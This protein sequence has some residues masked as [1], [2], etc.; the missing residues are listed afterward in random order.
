MELTGADRTTPFL[1]EANRVLVA[2][3]LSLSTSCLVMRLYTKGLILRKFWW[4]DGT[5]LM[6]SPN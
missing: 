4:D 6:L 2:V 1:Q 5:Q 3:G